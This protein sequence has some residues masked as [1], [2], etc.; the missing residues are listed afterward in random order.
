MSVHAMHTWF[1]CSVLYQSVMSGFASVFQ[2]AYTLRHSTASE[3]LLNSKK[4]KVD[5]WFQQDAHAKL[6][7]ENKYPIHYCAIQPA[8]LMWGSLLDVPFRIYHDRGSECTLVPTNQLERKAIFCPGDPTMLFCI[9]SSEA[10]L[11]TLRAYPEC[12][13]F[14]NAV[15]KSC[16]VATAVSGTSGK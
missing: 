12:S 16:G 8:S 14:C 3:Q 15:D 7:I 1:G 5:G 4:A 6:A 2:H 11:I 10:R 13:D 9:S